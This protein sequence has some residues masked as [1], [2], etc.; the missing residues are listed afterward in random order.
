MEGKIRKQYSIENMVMTDTDEYY[1]EKHNLPKPQL[2]NR[3]DSEAH[4]P[5][6]LK[7]Q[8]DLFTI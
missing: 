1:C 2:F 7:E 6:C 8:G 4:C 5:Y 3:G